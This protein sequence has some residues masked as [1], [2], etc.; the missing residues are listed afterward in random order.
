MYRA[1][2]CNP[3]IVFRSFYAV[4]KPFVD[5]VT[6]QKVCFVV[7]KKGMKQVVDDVGGP[8]IA[9]RQ[10]EKCCGGSG[11]ARDFDTKEYMKFLL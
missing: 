5:P 6:Q 7:G 1:Y 10:L 3:P 9:N 2:I 8:D 4:I 11:N